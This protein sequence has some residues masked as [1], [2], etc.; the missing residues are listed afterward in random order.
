MSDR[1]DAAIAS[2]TLKAFGIVT[3]EYKNMWWIKASCEE[4]DKNTEKKLEPR[5][6][7]Y[8]N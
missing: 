3:E 4:K 5:S 7:N 6:K 8:L 2:A 1:V